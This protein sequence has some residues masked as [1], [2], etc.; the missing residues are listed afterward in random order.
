MEVAYQCLLSLLVHPLAPICPGLE[1]MGP[2]PTAPAEMM[3]ERGKYHMGANYLCNEDRVNRE[4]VGER[5]RQARHIC[6]HH[7]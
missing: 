1:D 3:A 6:I 5:A 4:A 7:P 2:V